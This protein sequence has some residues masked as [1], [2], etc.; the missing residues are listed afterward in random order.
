[1]FFPWRAAANSSLSESEVSVQ[2]LVMA[3]IE[4]RGHDTRLELERVVRS[5]G[6]EQAVAILMLIGRYVT[7]AFFVN[8]LQLAPPDLPAL[9]SVPI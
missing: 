5:I 1:M 4:R 7:H 2:K 9:K 3:V 6:D 8:S